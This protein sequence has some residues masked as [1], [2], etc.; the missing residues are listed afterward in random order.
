MANIVFS[1]SFV[2]LRVR[3]L[4]KGLRFRSVKIMEVSSLPA[5]FAKTYRAF[6]FF[7]F[8]VVGGVSLFLIWTGYPLLTINRRLSTP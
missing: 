5:L 4:G 3:S 2:F 8:T 6:S 7:S 1:L